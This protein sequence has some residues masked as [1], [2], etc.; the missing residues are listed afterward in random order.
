M[1]SAS[2]KQLRTLGKDTTS[3]RGGLS[4]N[5]LMILQHTNDAFRMDTA[6]G[7]QRKVWWDIHY[8]FMRRASEND[9][10][11]TKN[12]FRLCRD[13]KGRKYL[14]LAYNERTKNHQG[15]IGDKD[16]SRRPR[17]YE[18][19]NWEMCPISSYEKYL[20]KLHPAM[21]WL[22]QRPRAKVTEQDPL[23]YC[24]VP[25]GDNKLCTMMKDISI[26]A[27][28]SK[29][30]TNHCPRATGITTLHQAGVN[31][32]HITCISGHARPESLVPY[33]MDSS[34]QQKEAHSEI[35][36]GQHRRKS[37][38]TAA[39]T[40]TRPTSSHHATS[41]GPSDSPQPEGFV[42]TDAF[43]E[44]G[45]TNTQIT[46]ME[47]EQRTNGNTQ[48]EQQNNNTQNEQSYNNTQT[49]QTLRLEVSNHYNIAS[50]C[51]VN[52]FC[53]SPG[54]ITSILRQQSSRNNY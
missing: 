32:L 11:L 9:R 34:E 5:D 19:P 45:P 14:E 47:N 16:S 1:F 33:I 46:N 53:L 52:I 37:S 7:L 51:T 3:H 25:V 49:Q 12:S 36:Q 54:Q 8:N 48:N 24:N 13:G 2:C 44:D 31:P 6:Y 26:I 42:F 39:E 40:F 30:Y 20:S 15:N 29:A 28:L 35:L 21:D 38:S 22:W 10:Q 50:G 17:M 18:I 23:W 27:Q 4:H 43:F 41:P